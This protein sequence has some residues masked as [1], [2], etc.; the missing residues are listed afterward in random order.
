[1]YKSTGVTSGAILLANCI[2]C[3]VFARF[4]TIHPRD[5][6]RSAAVN[7]PLFGNRGQKDER[8]AVN[9]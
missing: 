4:M 6:I 3:E 8:T 1:M 7:N 9:A 5:A 2:Q